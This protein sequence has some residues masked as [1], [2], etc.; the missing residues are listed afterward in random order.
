MG[1]FISGQKPVLTYKTY[2]F[3]LLQHIF[4]F[5]KSSWIWRKITS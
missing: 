1:T 5:I 4:N 3:N 2:I